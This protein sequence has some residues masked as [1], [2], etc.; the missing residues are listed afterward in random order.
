MITLSTFTLPNGLRVVHNRHRQ[1]VLSALEI[2]YLTGSRDESPDSTGLAH[3]FEHL[4]FGGT[5]DVA[6]FDAVIEAAGG[7]NNAATSS[8]YTYFYDILPVQNIETAFWLES[9][10][11][12]GLAFSEKSLEVQRHV[13]VE[14]FKETH[15]N[16]PYG[17]I[18]HALLPLLYGSHPY[19]WPVI[20]AVPEH[21]ER[22][23]IEQVKD[24]FYSHYAPNNAILTV[25]GDLSAE[26]V[27]ELAEKWFGPIPA[28]RIAPRVLPVDPWPV[29]E[30]EVTIY[31]R[32]PQT[33]ITI[34]YRMAPF[35]EPGY[36]A[37]DAISDIL[38]NGQ[39][40]RIP[41]RLV[42]EARIFTA[43][44]ASISG[45]VDS[46][47]FILSGRVAS[48]DLKAIENAK[49]A[50]IE[51]AQQ[52][53]RPGNVTEEELERAKNIYESNFTFSTITPAGKA[54][55]IAMAQA[56]GEDVNSMVAAYRALTT[57]DIAAEARRLFI[58]HAP[59][60]VICRPT[61]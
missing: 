24:W 36:L 41:K 51:Q 27:R 14:E 15:L 4:M 29:A 2:L 19:R 60:I 17:G 46:G 20:G 45:S 1:A 5:P 61:P 13:V 12:R 3:L 59:G 26:R 35:G 7:V 31:D 33:Q 43:A 55:T 48:E 40:T 32:V 54:H 58:D 30:R 23:T 37:A 50:L 6:E 9:D 25:V 57:A 34:A 49:Q 21:I 52:L 38:S 39:S 53:A 47:L 56:N 16:A 42:R 22:V 8:D 44:D 28:R 18:Q 10:R 11:M